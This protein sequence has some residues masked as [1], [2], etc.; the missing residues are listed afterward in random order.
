MSKYNFQAKLKLLDII[1]ADIWIKKSNINNKKSY[2]V[3]VLIL[4][5]LYDTHKI[6]VDGFVKAARV[7]FKNLKIYFLN[8]ES[9]FNAFKDD[10]IDKE[11]L[12]ISLILCDDNI[13]NKACS[14]LENFNEMFRNSTN[15]SIYLFNTSLVS[16]KITK[17]LKKLIWKDFLYII[18]YE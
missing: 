12:S 10:E 3:K 1:N 8:K 14:Y 5:D 4:D 18:N 17:D 13:K 16:D 9:I 15:N 7:N 11:C 6:V 2:I